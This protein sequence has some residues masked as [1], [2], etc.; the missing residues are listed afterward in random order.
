MLLVYISF[1][2]S[3]STSLVRVWLHL[4]YSARD[5]QKN[6]DGLVPKEVKCWIPT[7]SIIPVGCC[8]CHLNFSKM[9]TRLV[10]LVFWLCLNCEGKFAEVLSYSKDQHE[11]Y[12]DH[13]QW[14]V[15]LC[16]ENP[17]SSSLSQGESWS[18][19]QCISAKL[20]VIVLSNWDSV[21]NSK[22]VWTSHTLNS[23]TITSEAGKF[24]CQQRHCNW[25]Y[26]ATVKCVYFRQAWLIHIHDEK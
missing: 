19:H 9:L 13:F 1:I 25:L 14:Y 24:L 26:V 5:Y 16:S 15:R 10:I 7:S 18:L 23:S 21:K 17:R 20:H 12:Y 11:I 3:F 2:M 4:L 22:L 6:K 8:T